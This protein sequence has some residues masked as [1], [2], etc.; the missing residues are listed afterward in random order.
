MKH[1]R[2]KTVDIREIDGEGVCKIKPKKAARPYPSSQIREGKGQED[3]RGE[4]KRVEQK[5]AKTFKEQ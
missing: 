3:V 1:T 5:K 4:P 2:K